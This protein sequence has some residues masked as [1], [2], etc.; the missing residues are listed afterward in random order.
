MNTTVISTS[1]TVHEIQRARTFMLVEGN[2]CDL[3]DLLHREHFTGT[4][5]IHFNH[6]GV[7]AIHVIDRQRLD[8]TANM[9]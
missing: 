3:A 4:M 2:L 1:R 7:N 9:S 5:E 8:M 6:G